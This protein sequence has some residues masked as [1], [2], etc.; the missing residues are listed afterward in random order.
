[1]SADVADEERGSADI[2][3]LAK[4]R[5]TP[6]GDKY[7]AN[8]DTAMKASLRSLLPPLFEVFEAFDSVSYESSFIE[9]HGHLRPA[10]TLSIARCSNLA[11]RLRTMYVQDK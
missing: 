7:D 1:M 8:A 9:D 10:R 11:S 5:L 3:P 6:L 2:M 4:A